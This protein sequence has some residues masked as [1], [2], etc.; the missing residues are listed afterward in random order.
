MLYYYLLFAYCIA[1]IMLK[2]LKY[3]YCSYI[4]IIIKKIYSNISYIHIKIKFHTYIYTLFLSASLFHLALEQNE[5][6]GFFMVISLIIIYTKK[7]C[8]F[9]TN[10]HTKTQH[11]LH[12][13]VDTLFLS[14]SLFR[15][16]LHQN[17][18][19]GF[20]IVTLLIYTTH[21]TEI[22][23]NLKMRHLLDQ[24]FDNG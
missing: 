3:L 21:S 20:H 7:I 1:K 16:P 12:I 14:A 4:I 18:F 23:Y 13:N 6:F 22:S 9:S 8:K 17:R 11:T 5:L 10:I 19:S 2:S 24:P 15:I